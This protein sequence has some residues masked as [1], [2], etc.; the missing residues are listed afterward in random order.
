MHCG[1]NCDVI[2]VQRINRYLMQQ[3]YAVSA[4]VV[5]HIRRKMQAN[6]STWHW[7]RCWS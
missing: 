6:K 2:H 7:Q 1:N 3:Y 4:C 5:I